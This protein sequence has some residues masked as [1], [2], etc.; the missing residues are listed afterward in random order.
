MM[1]ET[2]SEHYDW[3]DHCYPDSHENYEG[4]DSP[5]PPEWESEREGI[6]PDDDSVEVSGMDYGDDEDEDDEQYDW[7]Y[8]SRVDEYG[9]A[10]EDFGY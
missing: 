10:G 2:M 8:E 7:E 4:Q 6:L 9:I 1:D 3:T 5:E